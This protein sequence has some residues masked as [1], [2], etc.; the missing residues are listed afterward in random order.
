M[1]TINNIKKFIES[2]KA[3]FPEYTFDPTARGSRGGHSWYYIFIGYDG[4][5]V[6]RI[7]LQPIEF[8]LWGVYY[9]KRYNSWA[10][11]YEPSDSLFYSFDCWLETGK[12]IDVDALIPLAKENRARK[13]EEIKAWREAHPKI[14]KRSK[15]SESWNGELC[16]LVKAERDRLIHLTVEEELDTFTAE[17]AKRVYGDM[18]ASD[19]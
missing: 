9:C 16:K 11:G 17:D 15:I 1:K 7:T 13:I 6:G 3:A 4:A 19:A 18:G 10:D 5:N 2:M 14:G 8:E 12:R